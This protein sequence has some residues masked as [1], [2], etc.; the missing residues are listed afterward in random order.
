MQFRSNAQRRAVFASL[1][2][3]F[4]HV[5]TGSSIADA[6][7]NIY[8][9]VDE[10]AEGSSNVG[11]VGDKIASAVVGL[12]P[13]PVLSNDGSIDVG[14]KLAFAVTRLYPGGDDSFARKS[15]ADRLREKFKDQLPEYLA[16]GIDFEAAYDDNLSFNENVDKFKKEFHMFIGDKFSVDSD[17]SIRELDVEFRDLKK[18][19]FDTT[20]SE[21][22]H[23]RDEISAMVKRLDQLD[24][25]IKK[26]N[27]FS[28]EDLF[29][30]KEDIKKLV[31][32]GE[33]KV[34]P[35]ARAYLD[36]LDNA[37]AIDDIR[38]AED[39][40]VSDEVI[41]REDEA[42]RTQALYI[43]SNLTSDNEKQ[44]DILDMLIAIGYN[45]PYT[46][47][48]SVSEGLEMDEIQYERL[49]D[50]FEVFSENRFDK[51]HK[52]G[53]NVFEDFAKSRNIPLEKAL[54]ANDWVEDALTPEASSAIKDA[55]NKV[56]IKGI[57]V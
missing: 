17:K 55:W 8:P 1:S 39:A 48:H 53:L 54:V 30:L 40:K 13:D 24:K 9:S 21:S 12:Y 47:K 46:K 6:V 23:D 28:S 42:V 50:A 44:D 15:G 49:T 57:N 20:N 16:T 34:N 29:S 27:S 32:S 22:R 25:E 38:Y 19:L 51:N 33:F 4:S 36:A 35:Y 2:N 7:V 26:K 45:K 37:E 5:Y 41:P 14:D 11:S 31:A 10:R 43:A 3:K 56:K 52:I 18:K